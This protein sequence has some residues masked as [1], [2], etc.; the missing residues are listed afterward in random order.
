MTDFNTVQLEL[1]PRGFAT[2]WLDRPDKNN[3]FNAEMIREL[4][5]AI[6]EVQAN[7]DLRF[8]LLRGRGK[9]FSAGADLAWMQQSA[10]LDFNANLVDARELAEMMYSLYHLKLP[11]LAIVQ[12]A[13]FGGA[14]GLIACCDMAIGAQDAQLS[15]SE[16]RIGLAPAVISPF[17]V[18]AIG[19]RATRRYAMTGERF[20]GERARE[21]GLLS[22]T[23]DGAEL[24]DSL[25]G[26]I[27]TLLLNSPQ[28]MR[29]SKD[30]LREA[31]S[32]SL[33]PALRRYTENAI[34]RIRVSPEGQEGLNAFLEKRKPNWMQEPQQ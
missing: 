9:H 20:S 26:W 28:A 13:A 12:G 22:E 11:T 32:G 17:V 5:L 23:Y 29:A 16:V 19:E 8:L 10:R 2:L 30:L 24:D 21:L 27:D 34:A 25:R 14:V 33:S 7:K 31:G 4:V 6:D 3:A 15:L 18:K 1:D